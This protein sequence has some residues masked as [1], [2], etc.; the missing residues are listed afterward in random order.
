MNTEISF[1]ASSISHRGPSA[2]RRRA[3]G[4]VRLAERRRQQLAPPPEF[5]GVTAQIIATDE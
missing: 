3:R 2:L 1:G 5:F 4:T